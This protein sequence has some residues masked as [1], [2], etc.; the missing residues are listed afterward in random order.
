LLA[1]PQPYLSYVV[2]SYSDGMYVYDP[3]FR[4]TYKIH[5]ENIVWERVRYD[6]FVAQKNGEHVIIKRGQKQ[7]LALQVLSRFSSFFS[8]EDK[9][10]CV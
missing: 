1:N 5:D 7:A 2:F 8:L 6:F 10:D 9:G 3:I 4:N